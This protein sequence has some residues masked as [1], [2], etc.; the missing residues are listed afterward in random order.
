MSYKFIKP[1]LK[2][3]Q[4]KINIIIEAILCFTFLPSQAFKLNENKSQFISGQLKFGPAKQLTKFLLS[5]QVRAQGRKNPTQPSRM[6]GGKLLG[7]G[8]YSSTSQ[9][10][11]P[12]TMMQ[13]LILCAI[14]NVLLLSVQTLLLNS[15]L[16]K[17]LKQLKD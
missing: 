10:I 2:S 1:L 13:D 8:A 3:C 9:L 14:C 7:R 6:S 16:L 4:Q 12:H 11:L 5:K 15:T 17:V